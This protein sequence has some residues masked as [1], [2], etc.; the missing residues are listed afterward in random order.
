M[1]TEIKDLCRRAD[2]NSKAM[3][4]H[5]V[6]QPDKEAMETLVGRISQQGL[7]REQVRKATR[8]QRGRPAPYVFKYQSPAKDFS[9]EVRFRRTQVDKKEIEQALTSVLEQISERGQ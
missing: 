6:R 8:P 2:I 1:P 5:I 4:L 3:L 9:L 7:T